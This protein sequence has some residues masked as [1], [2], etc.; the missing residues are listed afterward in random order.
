MILRTFAAFADLSPGHLAALAELAEERFFPAGVEV[1][2]EGVPV[3]EVHYLL[4]GQVEIRRRGR[5]VRRLGAR[6]V[7]GGLAALAHVADSHQVVAI[8]D[9]TT[10]SFTH[11]DQVDVF[12]DNFEMMTGILRGVAGAFIEARLAVGP[13]AGFSPDVDP[14]TPPSGPLDLVGKLAVLRR[15]VPFSEA[16]IEALSEMA[17]ESPERR[18]PAGTALW[19]LADPPG[20]SLLVVSGVIEGETE[21]GQTFGLGPDSIAGGLDSLAGRSRWFRAVARTDLTVLELHLG[22]LLDVLEDHSDL[23]M[24]LLRSMAGGVLALREKIAGAGTGA[25]P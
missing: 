18:H 9:T 5:P 24:D 1:H 3:R 11:E 22:A 19:Q 16:R 17:R 12:E 14:G 4:T 10:F 8:E 20:P 7:I 13:T 25:A 21:R 15:T 2:P 23:A 6:S